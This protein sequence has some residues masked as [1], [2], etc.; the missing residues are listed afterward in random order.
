MSEERY[1]QAFCTP[2]NIGKGTAGILVYVRIFGDIHWLFCTG[3]A[4]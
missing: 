4:G 1:R 3:K 2:N